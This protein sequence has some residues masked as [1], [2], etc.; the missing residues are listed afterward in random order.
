MK[1]SPNLNLLTIEGFLTHSPEYHPD[2]GKLLTFSIAHNMSEDIPGLDNPMYLDVR[3][4]GISEDTA[5]A[6][7]KGH[8]VRVTGKLQCKSWQGKDDRKERYFFVYVP[9]ASQLELLNK[10]RVDSH[11]LQPA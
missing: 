5:N 4:T 7:V 1:Q 6:I 2:K 3:V 8:K 11:E 9:Y 10:P